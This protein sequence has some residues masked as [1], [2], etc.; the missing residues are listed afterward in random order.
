M[1]GVFFRRRSAPRAEVFNDASRDVHTFF[2]VLQRHYTG[3]VEMM[4]YQL[5]MRAEF[6]RLVATDPDALTDLERSAR[7]YYLQRTAFGGKVR[8][9]T[10]GVSPADASRFDITKLIPSSSSRTRGSPASRWRRFPSPTSSRGTIAQVRCSTAIRRT[11]GARTTMGASS[12]RAMTSSDSPS[13][14]RRSK[15]ASSCR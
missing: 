6:E 5:T 3:F 7:F 15:V 13:S 12:S 9:R 11:T 2:R 1:G 8:G 10:F 14:L 4:R